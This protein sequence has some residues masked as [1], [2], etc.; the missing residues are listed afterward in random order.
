[1]ATSLAWGIIGA[2]GIARTFANGLAR[3]A[4]GRLVAVASRA[5][6]KAA[7]FG[8]QV[9]LG[10][11]R[12]YGAYEA[13]LADPAVEAVYIATPHPMHAQWAIRAAEAGKH[14]LC[15]K[16]IGLN[17]YEAMAIVEAARRHDVFLMEAFMYRCHPQTA[18]LVELIRQQT[19][20]QVRVIQATFSFHAGFNPQGRL[21]ANELG[22][23]GI[24]DV[25]CYCTS[26]SRLVAGAAVGLPFA[27]PLEVRGAGHL[28]E[29]GVDEW[30][31]ATARFPGDIVAQWATGVSLNQEN[32]LRVFGSEGHLVVPSPWVPARDGGSTKIVVKL[33]REPEAQEIIVETDA[34]LYALE[35]DTVAA[36]LEQ[37][38]AASPAMTWD[39]TLGN[40]RALDQWR[41]SM[42]FAYRA[43]TP[44][45]AR[46]V[47]WA[48]RSVTRNATA[49]MRY[50]AIPGVEKPVAR[51]VMGVDNQNL[52]P[53]AEMMFDDYFANG[54]NAFD[55]AWVY[56]REKSVNLGAWVNGRGV[57][58]QVVLIAKG[59]HTPM[60]TPD[61]IGR[62]LDDWLSWTNTGYCD[63]YMLHRDNLQVPVG[64]FVD[65]LNEQVR[66][67]R[68]RAFGGSN[69][70]LERVDEANAYA[71]RHGLGG[72]A[73]VSNNMSLAE[74][75][76]A[77]WAGCIHASDGAS[78]AW[79]TRTQMALLPWSSQARGFFTERADAPADQQSDRE[80][81]RCWYSDANRER[82][83]RAIDLAQQRGVLPINIALAYVLCQP[84]PTF[85]L[86][87]PRSL[88]E[89]RTSLPAL[90]VALT[91]AEL[92]WLNL[93]S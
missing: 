58:D 9:G 88:S 45:S 91:P 72:F 23:G 26:M 81:V 22:G 82:R 92:A 25:G 77:V 55:T 74:M 65:A 80:M 17:Q 60:C 62:Q 50:G 83:R 87:G 66:A 15:E 86:I 30:A 28:G 71:A 67:G 34:Y 70:T 16:P 29:T 1:M 12:C 33:N 27:E 36:H 76:E 14:I 85:P 90:D 10:P 40:M 56:G 64:E 57:R 51:L 59:A 43:E 3:S 93:E 63:V 20:G 19:I 89:T 44:A 78:R 48:G 39:D 54:G 84:F 41:A 8:A 47:N 7:A 38:Q 21:F 32:V 5:Q 68:V 6:E 42:G 53:H 2:G 73:V 49:P 35:A 11:D 46:A 31:V 52:F 75:I 37:R 61:A 69:W 18:R 13:L 79:F 4:T 24:L